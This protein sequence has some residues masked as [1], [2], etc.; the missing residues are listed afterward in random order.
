VTLFTGCAQLLPKIIVARMI[1]LRPGEVTLPVPGVEQPVPLDELDGKQHPS[2]YKATFLEEHPQGYM[3]LV[4][5]PETGD[6]F[7]FLLKPPG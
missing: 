1:V 5:H 6:A 4:S 3:F 2:G 7:K